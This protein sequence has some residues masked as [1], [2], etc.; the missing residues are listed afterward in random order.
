V[1]GKELFLG[2][3]VDQKVKLT[4]GVSK[5]PYLI[6]GSMGLC[7]VLRACLPTI[8]CDSLAIDAIDMI[9]LEQQNATCKKITFMDLLLDQPTCV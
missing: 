4:P 1:L 5:L 6:F 7:G 2:I 8:K 9:E 3:V